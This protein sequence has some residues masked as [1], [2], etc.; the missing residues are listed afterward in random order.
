MIGTDGEV[1][2][3]GELLRRARRVAAHLRG[4]GVGPDVPVG[5]FLGRSLDLAAAILGVLEAGGAYLPLDPGYPR[6]R[7][8]LMLE[9]A[10]VPV[11]LTEPALLDALP[12]GAGQQI[13]RAHV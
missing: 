5:I 11:V 8:R 9:D 7:L 1:L 3:Y 2:S 10:R 13:G 12:E 4:A 6:E